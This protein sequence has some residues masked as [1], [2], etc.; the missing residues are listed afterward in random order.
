MTA[1]TRWT[2]RRAA[3]RLRVTERTVRTYCAEGVLSAERVDGGA[4]SIAPASVERLAAARE[5]TT[6]SLARVLRLHRDTVAEMVDDG[7]LRCERSAGGTVRRGRA[8]IPRDSVARMLGPEAA[9]A[10]AHALA[11]E[12]AANDDGD[13]LDDTAAA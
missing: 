11:A 4:Y 12:R 3:T 5:F 13:A 9:L 8:F 2:V 10:L 6:A 7:R 1:S